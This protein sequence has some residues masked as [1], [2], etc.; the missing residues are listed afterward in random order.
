M[1]DIDRRYIT[2]NDYSSKYF[3]PQALLFHREEL[4]YHE[5]NNTIIK[6]ESSNEL[7]KSIYNDMLMFLGVFYIECESIYREKKKHKR[8]SICSNNENYRRSI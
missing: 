7:N 6:K 5:T 4:L 8:E 2:Y 3:N 1:R